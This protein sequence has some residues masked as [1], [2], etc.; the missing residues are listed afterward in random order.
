MCT[1]IKV[2]ILCYDEDEIRVIVILKM[3]YVADDHTV[4][5]CIS[6]YKVKC[7]VLSLPRTRNPEEIGQQDVAAV[8][9]HAS[10]K[11]TIIGL[12]L[13]RMSSTI[14]MRRL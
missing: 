13:F 4:H 12:L 5:K 8:M 1:M 3:H 14:K 7:V 9:P 10:I 6:L 2:Y 11:F